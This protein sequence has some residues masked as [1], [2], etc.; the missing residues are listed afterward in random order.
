MILVSAVQNAK[1]LGLY[2]ITMV[3]VQKKLSATSRA[4]IYVYYPSITTLRAAV[5]QEALDKHY[6]K[7][8][9]EAVAMNHPLTK[10]LHKNDKKYYLTKLV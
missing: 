3:T 2:H 6:E 4:T 10:D 7:L 5:V 8:I 1:E 9:G